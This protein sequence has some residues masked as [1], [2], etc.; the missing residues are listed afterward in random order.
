MHNANIYYISSWLLLNILIIIN[1]INTTYLCNNNILKSQKS[2]W[3]LQ[4][5][6]QNSSSWEKFQCSLSVFIDQSAFWL[7]LRYK[8]RNNLNKQNKQTVDV[9]IQKSELFKMWKNLKPKKLTKA[10]NCAWFYFYSIIFFSEWWKGNLSLGSSACFV[11]HPN[12]T[13]STAFAC[14]PSPTASCGQLH[15][16]VAAHVMSQRQICK[17]FD[18]LGELVYSAGFKW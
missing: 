5:V 17:T 6:E 1:Y 12:R 16:N 8:K 11:G 4:L 3:N 7:W 9:C 10:T 2:V 15:L 14:Q 18:C 13:A